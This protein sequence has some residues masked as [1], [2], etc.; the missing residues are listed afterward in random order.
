METN[1]KFVC[2]GFAVLAAVL[3]LQ[4]GA[5]GQ[6]CSAPNWATGPTIWAAE[7]SIKV[8]QGNEPATNQPTIPVD[9]NAGEFD[10]NGYP[11]HP[12]P[13]TQLNPAWSCP[14]GAPTI[15]VA[16]AGRETVAFQ[17]MITAG[18]SAALSNVSVTISPLT[19]PGTTITSDN[20]QG[21][22]VTRY[23]EGYIPE[24]Y[25]GPTNQTFSPAI[26]LPVTG[27]FPDP[28]I[29]FYDPYD[30]GNGPVATPFNVAAGTTQGVWVDIA[31]PYNQATGTYT[32][33]VTVTGNGV[34]TATYPLTLTVWNGNLPRFNDPNEPGLLKAWIPLYGSELQAAEGMQCL[35]DP[36]LKA[37]VAACPDWTLV[38][39]YLT[40]AHNYDFDTQVD[41]VGPTLTPPTG[42]MSD[43]TA[44][45][46]QYPTAITSIDWTNWDNMNGPA[47]T[48]G[49]L[50]AD[51]SS[52]RV[53]DA[54]FSGGG[55]PFNDGFYEYGPLAWNN[56]GSYDIN[57][58]P[59]PGLLQ[60]FTSYSMQKSQH[61]T[62][63]QQNANW[64]KN[65]EIIAYTFDETYD[66]LTGMSNLNT[67][68]EQ[69]AQA[70]NAANATNHWVNPLRFFLT[71]P[72]GCIPG[73]TEGVETGAICTAQEG[74][75][76][77]E[78]GGIPND[79]IEDWSPNG[80]FYEP[81]PSTD[82]PDYTMDGIAVHSSAP[83]PIEKWMYG[84][85]DPF[86]PT[87]AINSN[88]LGLRTFFW[89]AAKYGLDH[90]SPSPGDPNPVPTPGGAFNFAANYWAVG[91][92]GNPSSASDCSTSPFFNG[93]GGQGW[94]G[95][96]YYF[97][98]GNE[99]GCY[100]QA[101]SLGTPVGAT[102]LTANPVANAGCS[103]TDYSICN[104]ING[105]VSSMTMEE[106]RRGYEDYM[107]IYLLR[108][109]NSIQAMAIVD[110]MGGGGS[111]NWD[112]L[113]WENADPDYLISGVFPPNGGF[114]NGFDCTAPSLG[115]PNG[116]T[117]AFGC[118]GEWSH[119][120][121]HYEEA[122]ITIAQDLGFVS[123]SALPTVTAIS[124][125]SGPAAGGTSVTITG[126]GF[127]TATVIN[128][129]NT[130]AHTFTINSATQ[131]T[132]V[133]PA[134]NGTVDVTV[135][136]PSGT[137]V[138]SAADHFAYPAAVIVPPTVTAVSP[139][140]GSV[141]GGTSV[142]ITGTNFT[143][144]TAVDFGGTAATGLTINSATQITAVSPK[145]SN[146]TV[147]VTVVTPGG[148]S[149]V[150]AADQFVFT[151]GSYTLTENPTTVTIKAGQTGNTTLT[152][153]PAGGYTG[154]VILN[155]LNLPVHT[156]CVFSQTGGGGSTVTMSGNNQ[157][158][159]VAL[160]I[161]TNV[162]T[163]MAMT[164][165]Q[166]SPLN[167]IL[168]ALAFWWPGGIVG[169]AGFGRRKKKGLM[170]SQQRLLR[171]GLLV[172]MTGAMAG[173]LA[174]C[175]GGSMSNTTPAGTSTVTVTSTAP[176][177]TSGLS[178]SVN[179]TLTITR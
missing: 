23:L 67:Y 59:P 167:P 102:I 155:C 147:D 18:A 68:M 51:G 95:N 31:I 70:L 125:T 133:S 145:G 9:V 120:P 86:T 41:G 89:I 137:S 138:S 36:S 111:K 50:F 105:P 126:T 154:S 43:Q 112:A 158:V 142:T 106:W 39:E 103:T 139:A 57:T 47:L 77:P 168:P 119:N 108:K 78:V 20:T 81:G 156:A 79:W 73:A 117:G 44:P 162:A 164:T 75:S 94:D 176:A 24:T 128:F 48:P 22:A 132:A 153:T 118:P 46:Y 151:P 80:G 134:G 140:T 141:A 98:P 21:S 84:G 65:S 144:A 71:T 4:A 7:D 33:T 49:G 99:I 127:T 91:D 6:A 97:Y 14:A 169:L 107:Y 146:G 170:R 13:L 8:V 101:N 179:F 135:S 88:A 160:T 82:T 152:L 122:R 72:P 16:G 56:Y 54:P 62:A 96:G 173:V 3:M 90:T 32:G 159:Q 26:F 61:F 19:G 87:I 25:P 157:P 17:L 92:T 30:A 104:G 110:S 64:T 100:Y 83:V 150:N 109:Q 143:G 74:L 129:G 58:P 15:S 69:Y 35:Y 40:M 66:K 28:L 163:Q 161:E 178:Q 45:G 37:T 166:Q 93:A 27:N 11:L 38:H 149:A 1:R 76:Y 34:G 123:A 114:G 5:L 85:G 116:P 172:L 136:T 177:G 148:T 53:I 130:I 171:I 131:I 2:S 124:P 165:G 115:L 121:N 175:G 52:M 63:Q 174:G 42:F 12:A 60:L 10:P 113:N 29:P 55:G